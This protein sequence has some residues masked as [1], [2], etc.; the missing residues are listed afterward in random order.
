MGIDRAGQDE[1]A[2]RVDHLVGVRDV[3]VL[4]DGRDSA[5]ANPDRRARVPPG[6]RHDPVQ[7]GHLV[8]RHLGPLVSF[9]R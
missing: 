5:V 9:R 2:L 4:A 1:P 3:V 8:L 7:H 6:K